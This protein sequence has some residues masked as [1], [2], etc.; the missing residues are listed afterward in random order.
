MGLSL[1]A[2]PGRGTSK[3]PL[4]S[5]DVRLGSIFALGFDG[6]LASLAGLADLLVT[7]LKDEVDLI[8]WSASRLSSIQVEGRLRGGNRRQPGC[9]RGRRPSYW[10]VCKQLRPESSSSG[11]L[12]ITIASKW[13][14]DLAEPIRGSCRAP[15]PRLFRAL[16]RWRFRAAPRASAMKALHTGSILARC[17]LPWPCMSDS[18]DRWSAAGTARTA[19]LAH[20]RHVVGKT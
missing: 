4:C 2:L 5:F 11:K 13:L 6:G 16:A 15:A 18:C 3:L 14:P 20:L 1:S 12:A 9:M 7:E 17:G 8:I 10:I 19:R